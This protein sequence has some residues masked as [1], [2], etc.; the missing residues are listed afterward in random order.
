MPSKLPD[1]AP[2]RA[3]ASIAVRKAHADVE[4]DLRALRA[5]LDLWAQRVQSPVDAVPIVQS[6]ARVWR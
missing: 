6:G 2:A 5:W 4:R 3:E 1:S